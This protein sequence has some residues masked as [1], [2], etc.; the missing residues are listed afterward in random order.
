MT[1]PDDGSG[2]THGAGGSV[3]YAAP[4][5][6]LAQR[7]PPFHPAVSARRF[8]SR[9]RRPGRILLH[10]ASMSAVHDA[11]PRRPR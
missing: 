2:I 8:V 1:T 10:P 4:E 11:S 7:I 9:G 3:R 6:I 5:E